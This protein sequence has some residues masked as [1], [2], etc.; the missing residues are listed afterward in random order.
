MSLNYF[1]IKVKAIKDIRAKM[2]DAENRKVIWSPYFGCSNFV[3]A[4]YHA[5]FKDMEKLKKELRKETEDL[6]KWLY[7]NDFNI[8][9]HSR[10][11]APHWY[12]WILLT[13]FIAGFAF[14]WF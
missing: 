2:A 4:S 8:F 9:D 7:D 13:G 14:R 3:R 10:G 5:A 1:H 11:H 12:I 6:S